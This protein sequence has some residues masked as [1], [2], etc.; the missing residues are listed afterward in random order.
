V[1]LTVKRSEEGDGCVLQVEARPAKKLSRPQAAE[2]SVERLQ[3]HGNLC[4][5]HLKRDAPA[6]LMNIHGTA[7]TNRTPPPDRRQRRHRQIKQKLK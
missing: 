7:R 3:L 5:L 6:N 1:G 4:V 2:D